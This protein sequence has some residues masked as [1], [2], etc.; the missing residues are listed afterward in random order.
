MT[1]AD[2]PGKIKL[3]W[4]VSYTSS[5][6]G[7]QQRM[8]WSP[9]LSKSLVIHELYSVS[10]NCLVKEEVSPFEGRMTALMDNLNFELADI[11]LKGTFK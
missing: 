5:P 2:K 9:Q 11:F 8:D 7:H 10:G 3:L 4:Y 6:C 1:A